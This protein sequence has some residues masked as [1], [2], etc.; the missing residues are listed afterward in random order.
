MRGI[1][2]T[3]VDT[4]TFVDVEGEGLALLQAMADVIGPQCDLIERVRTRLTQP[5]LGNLVL[6][7]D[8]SGLY[9]DLQVN[10]LATLLYNP[11]W[12]PRGDRNQAGAI[13]GNAILFREV[14]DFEEGA[15]FASVIESDLDVV[16]AYHAQVSV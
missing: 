15:D 13:V 14:F 3:P 1:L 8:E 2:I 10:T 4:M 5:H 6:A 12:R 11:R 16:R 7:T 9:H